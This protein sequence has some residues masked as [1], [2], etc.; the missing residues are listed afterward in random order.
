MADLSAFGGKALQSLRNNDFS[1]FAAIA[2]VIDNSIEAEAKTI[3]IKI[4][5][6]VPE[7]LR[8][9]RP[10]LIAFGDDGHGMN[11]NDLQ[12]CMRYGHS[13][14]YNSRKGIG[15]FGVGMTNGAISVCQFIEVYSREKQGNWNYT[16]LDIEDRPNNQDPQLYPVEQRLLPKEFKE[17]VGDIGTLVVWS[18]IDRIEADFD[19]NEL[20]HWI[21][22]VYRKFIGERILK[23]GKIIKNTNVRKIFID[24]GNTI[25]EIRAFDP[26]YLIPEQFQ[27][28]PENETSS[29]YEEQEFECP[30][31]SVDAPPSGE[32]FGKVIIRTSLTPESWRHEQRT[33]GRSTENNAR[34]VYEN[35]GFSFLRAG[36]EVAYDTIPHPFQPAPVVHDRFWSC[37][38]EFDPVLD[39][40]F[41]VKNIKRGAKPLEELRDELQKKLRGK[42]LHFREQIEDHWS[43]KKIEKNQGGTGSTN[44]HQSAEEATRGIS[45]PKK[46]E[47]SKEEQ[48]KA[49]EEFANERKLEEEEKIEFLKKVLDPNGPPFIIEEDPNGRPDGPFIDIVPNLG[50][51]LITYNLKHVFFKNVYDKLH[52]VDELAKVVKKPEDTR[53]IEI[54]NELKID[55]DFLIFAF[56]DSKYDITGE[57]GSKSQNVDD[58]MEDLEINWSDK[59]RRVYRN[60][61]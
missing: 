5:S 34:W 47:L 13:T 45:K 61:K 10:V 29:S 56:A 8:K 14:R 19:I 11:K 30:V 40:Q 18:K 42:I 33:S 6:K 12:F 16:N 54:A 35:E 15:R 27:I 22:R 43:T 51:K 28:L 46:T 37:E 17:L 2:E 3:K 1:P 25:E 60:K 32:K 38:I 31:H 21:G 39:H 23:N 24:D 58:T 55:I 49:A 20:K 52:E 50:K 48:K 9:P 4:K 7:G 36:R 44:K 53:L 41:S 26:M 59:L 57:I